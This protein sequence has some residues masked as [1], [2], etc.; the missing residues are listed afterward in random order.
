MTKINIDG[1]DCTP[2]ANLTQGTKVSNAQVVSNHEDYIRPVETTEAG[3]VI[4]SLF[5]NEYDP[6][7]KTHG[8]DQKANLD[9]YQ[10]RGLTALDVLDTLGFLSHPSNSVSMQ[11]KFL[12]VSLN[13][14]GR[15]DHVNIMQAKKEQEMNVN[16]GGMMKGLLGMGK[17]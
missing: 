9:S 1:K 13:A 10:V 7:Q 3:Q 8:I 14:R 5:K 15:D 16:G 4:E 11:T 2:K 6:I 17:K 12:S